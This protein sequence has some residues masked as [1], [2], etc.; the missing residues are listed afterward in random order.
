MVDLVG[1]EISVSNK[2]VFYEHCSAV[3][4]RES[5]ILFFYHIFQSI[6]Q[7][8]YSFEVKEMT[9]LLDQM[10]VMTILLDQMK[11]MHICMY[12]HL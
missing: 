11:V 3:L 2:H 4:I 10:K 7:S 9:I 6:H 8:K 5:I 1:M 12:F